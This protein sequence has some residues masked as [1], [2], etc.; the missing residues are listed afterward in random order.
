MGQRVIAMGAYPYPEEFKKQAV[1]KFINRGTKSVKKLSE[2]LNTSGNNLYRW[3]NEFNGN[4]AMAKSKAESWSPEQKLKAITETSSMSENEL[5][6]YLR[7]HG[8]HSSDLKE[9]RENFF[10]SQK[11]VGR[12]RKDPEVFELRKK[13]KS[14]K[15][16][17]RRKEKAL[18][19]MSAR[20]VL[21][22]KSREIFGDDE[23]EE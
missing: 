19:E 15:K 12:P 9:W 16:D 17:L 11:S 8:L 3:C 13:E 22:K 20:V 5:G 4:T 10:E 18:A 6:E 7:K 23:D 1:L 2:E 21:L 14:L